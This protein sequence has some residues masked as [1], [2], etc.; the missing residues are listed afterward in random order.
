MDSHLMSLMVLL[1]E[2]LSLRAC[3]MLINTPEIIKPLIKA[4]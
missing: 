3:A 1:S 2:K 4:A